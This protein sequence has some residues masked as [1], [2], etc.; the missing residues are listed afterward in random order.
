M[1]HYHIERLK[2]RGGLLHGYVLPDVWGT[3]PEATRAAREKG[4]TLVNGE[5]LHVTEKCNCK[6][7][8]E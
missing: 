2:W 4:G 3:L 8:G 5:S 1:P 7:G 6:E